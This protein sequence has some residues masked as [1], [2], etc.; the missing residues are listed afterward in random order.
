M[1]DLL[2]QVADQLGTPG[3][4]RVQ[5]QEATAEGETLVSAA[6]HVHR[7][8]TDFA[9]NLRRLGADVTVEPDAVEMYW[10]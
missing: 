9:G 1:L 4:M 3:R 5:E 8:Y 7:G 6:H 2:G 10:N